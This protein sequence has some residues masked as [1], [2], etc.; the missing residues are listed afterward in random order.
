MIDWLATKNGR[1][2]AFFLL[3]ITEGIPLGYTAI[4]VATLMRRE[5]ISPE[6]IGSFV[7]SLYLPWSFKWAAGP[8]V[9]LFR[10]RRLGPRRAW[11]VGT[12]T[13]MTLA[14]LVCA[15][16]DVKNVM[17]FTWVV[18]VSN[19]FGAIQDVAIDALAV[20]TLHESE[21]GLA[22]G[23]MFAGASVG[24]A[25]GGSGAL[26]LLKY[27]G[28][29]GSTF[30]VI[31][32]LGAVLLFVSLWLRERPDPNA[33][34]LLTRENVGG[35]LLGYVKTAG[36]A[37][38]GSGSNRLSIAFVLIPAGGIV[39]SYLL[40]PVLAGLFGAT[41]GV[42]AA[43]SL[44]TLL[45]F[46]ILAVSGGVGAAFF[47][48]PRS[49]LGLVLALLP[50]GGHALGLALQSNLAVELGMSDD[51]IGTLNLASTLVFA[52]FCAAGGWVSDYFGRVRC[53]AVFIALTAIPTLAFAY[54]LWNGGW[55]MP[56]DPTLPNRP[57][58]AGWLITGLW[59]ATLTFNIANGL[60]Y[61]TRSAFYMDFC[62]PKVAATQFTA[63]MAL[64]NLVISYTSYWQGWSIKRWGYPVTLAL[65]AAFGLVCLAVLA[66]V[67]IARRA[68]LSGV[69]AA[70]PEAGRCAVC[71]AGVPAGAAACPACGEATSG[72]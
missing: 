72:V 34:S 56:V 20:D 64:M 60:M 28:F 24:Q 61:G 40:L 47:G 10:S 46:A 14:L 43:I 38:L 39:F 26:F 9:D 5:G 65:D 12:Q 48:A 4:F 42:I 67:P 31:A 35:E 29:A 22:N 16:V 49:L 32:C 25:I 55:I 59:G 27:A 50:A 6:V 69:I 53:L 8:F 1:L 54:L 17:L 66:V 44:G 15:G 57:T 63:Y 41:G 13:A 18:V 51:Q 36:G 30:F 37:F 3:Y 58:P 7:A 45:V 33:P 68:D 23:L 70:L 71:G 52:V 11:I 21:R 2:A 62:D 19:V